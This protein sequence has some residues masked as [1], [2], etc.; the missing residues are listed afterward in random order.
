VAGKNADE[1]L[2]SLHVCFLQDDC[3]DR[4]C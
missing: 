2:D 4:R 1:Q 3:L